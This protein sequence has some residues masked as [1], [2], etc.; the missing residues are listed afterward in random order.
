MPSPKPVPVRRIVSAGSAIAPT[1]NR[2]P[3]IAALIL[4]DGTVRRLLSNDA[5]VASIPFL[6]P[7]ANK[8][9]Q[10]QASKPK[11][12][13]CGG[14]G[15]GTSQV[16]T[17]DVDYNVVRYQIANAGIEKQALIKTAL[18]VKQL[19]VYYLDASGNRARAT[20]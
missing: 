13:G 19:R 7:F 15:G 4:D 14:C 20:V 12:S 10:A 8:Y 2:Q 11:S 1:A 9:K 16:I 5:L 3:Q 6:A 17:G 18:N